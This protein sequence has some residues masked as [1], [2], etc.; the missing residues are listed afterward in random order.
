M[1]IFLRV[2]GIA[3]LVGGILSILFAIYYWVVMH[4]NVIPAKKKFLPFTGP[5]QFILPHLWNEAGN[6]ARIKLILSFLIFGICFA[7]NYLFLGLLHNSAR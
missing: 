1:I 5:L 4:A 3:S 2:L 7:S 6:R